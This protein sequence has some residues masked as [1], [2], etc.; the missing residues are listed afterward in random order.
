MAYGRRP[1][2]WVFVSHKT[3]SPLTDRYGTADAQSYPRPIQDAYSGA[4]H[5]QATRGDGYA[6]I[7]AATGKPFTLNLNKITGST[8]VGVRS[9]KRSVTPIGEL[10][11]SRAQQFHPPGEPRRGNDWVLVLDDKAKGFS[12]PGA[13]LGSFRA[14]Q[15]TGLTV[16]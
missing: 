8:V 12:A 5:L 16:Y 6:F 10:P 4:D 13:P 14:T 9:P 15:G 7:Y 3:I 2:Y 1:S 11:N